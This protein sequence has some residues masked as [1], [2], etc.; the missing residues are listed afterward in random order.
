MQKEQS[1]LQTVFRKLDIH[2]KKSNFDLT[3]YIKINSSIA[4]AAVRG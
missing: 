3:P 1:F 4:T 2:M